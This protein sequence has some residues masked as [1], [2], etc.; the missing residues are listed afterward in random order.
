MLSPNL[1]FF[2]AMTPIRLDGPPFAG[3]T[4]FMGAQP[5]PDA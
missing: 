2:A 3:I 4:G 1:L 5:E